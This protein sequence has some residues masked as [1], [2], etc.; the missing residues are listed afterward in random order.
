MTIAALQRLA[1]ACRDAPRKPIYL[2][3]AV[4]TIVRAS[5]PRLVITRAGAERIMPLAR[6]ARVICGDAVEWHGAAIR[7][8]LELRIPIVWVRT[9]GTSLGAAISHQGDDAPM[10]RALETYTERADW[11]TRYDGWLRWRRMQVLIRWSREA[12]AAEHA[13]LP[14]E[15]TERK[16][17]F[18]H[19]AELPAGLP[20]FTRAWCFAAVSERLVRLRIAP[21]YIGYGGDTL[22]LARDVTT[23]LWSAFAFDCGSIPHAAHDLLVATTLC[24]NWLR[25]H[26]ARIDDHIADLARHV[27][28]ANDT[29]H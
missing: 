3:G 23:L 7:A 15:F 16:R 29:W 1:L 25:L 27:R 18:V 19:R 26:A 9:D 12:A 10:H 20:E 2:L 11:H 6:I 4:R 14:H 28:R 13:P 21:H 17:S 5:G 8:C 24:E 22:E